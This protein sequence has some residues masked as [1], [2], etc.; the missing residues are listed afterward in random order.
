[1]TSFSILRESIFIVLLGLASISFISLFSYDINDAGFN[2]TG[3][4]S[5][6]NNYIGLFGAYFSSFLFSFFGLA[7]YFLPLL[8]LS[9]CIT[10]IQGAVSKID[11]ALIVIRVLSFFILLISSSTLFSIHIGLD[12]LSEGSGGITGLLFSSWFIENLGLTGST[13]ILMAVI[14]SF[15]PLM[16]GFSWLKVSDFLGVHLIKFINKAFEV[17]SKLLS[18][19]QDKKKERLKN[20][21]QAP[22]SELKKEIKKPLKEKVVNKLKKSSNKIETKIKIE[23]TA[24]PIEESKKATEQRQVKMFD[25]SSESI[26]PDLSILNEAPAQQQGASKE[27]LEALSGLLE[28]KLKDFGITATVEEILPGPIVTRFEINPAPGVKVSQISNLSKD[29]ARSL[30]VSSVRIVEVIEGKSFIGIE[31]PNEQRDLVVLGEIL[32]SKTFE[33]FSSPLTIALGKDI[34]G[35]PIVADLQKMPHLLIAGTTGSGKSVGINAMIISLLYKSTPRDVRMILIDPKMLELSVYG[36]IPH[37]LCP[38]VTDMKEA[39][40]ALRWC[41]VEM[42][43]RYKLMSKLKVRNLKGLNQKIEDAIASGEPIKDPL[44]DPKKEVQTTDNIEPPDLE[45]LPNIVVVVD[46]LADMMITVGKKVEQLIS[47]LAAKARASGIHMIIATQRPSVDVIT[48]L[49][50]A[51]IPS[52]IAFQVSAKVDSRTILDQMGAENLLGNGDMLYIPPGSSSPVRVHGA[53]VSDDEVN[54]VSGDL[55]SKSQPVF[56]DEVTT[57][58]LET[59][60]PGEAPST[61]ADGDSESDPLFDEAVALVTESRNASISSVQR[62]LRIGYNRAARIVEKME[63]IGIVGELESNGKREV[64]APPPP[65]N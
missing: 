17:F 19:I 65:E 23:K 54:A 61:D 12:N 64:L 58:Q 11:R 50:K 16:V 13:V 15:L 51:N 56:I 57:G 28:L 35:I 59:P 33:D 3:S 36:G 60:I 47:R 4:N 38:V 44:F 22:K 27:S 43:R 46:E 20:K 37:L 32:R 9:A 39:A 25:S 34:A 5:E 24:P 30:S 55:Q 41:V 14:L 10:L 7:S 2:T 40:N 62:K 52:R 29:L 63:E 53:F 45:P 31:I 1:M 42:E 6:V 49:I 21:T 48:G 26:I 8:F 18:M